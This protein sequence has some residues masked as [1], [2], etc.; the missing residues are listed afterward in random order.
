MRLHHIDS[1]RVSRQINIVSLLFCKNALPRQVDSF[2]SDLCHARR[3]ADVSY[4]LAG[5]YERRTQERIFGNR[6]SKARGFMLYKNKRFL[7]RKTG[8]L[9]FIR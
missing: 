3:V 1:F 9:D 6:S 8:S 7:I 5:V 4:S 2:Y